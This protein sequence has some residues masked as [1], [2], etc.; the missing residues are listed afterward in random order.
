MVGSY[1]QNPESRDKALQGGKTLF[2]PPSKLG[3][4]F[5]EISC[6]DF[7]ASLRQIFGSGEFLWVPRFYSASVRWVTKALGGQI[8]R[9]LTLRKQVSYPPWRVTCFLWEKRQKNQIRVALG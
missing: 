5:H 4:G 7:S 6:P 9:D 8:S 1:Y 2:A 3:A